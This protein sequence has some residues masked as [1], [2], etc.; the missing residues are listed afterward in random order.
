ML[1]TARQVV[2][3]GATADQASLTEADAPSPV[4]LLRTDGSLSRT[5]SFQPS[6][7]SRVSTMEESAFVDDAWS[8]RS[9]F[10]V[11]AGVRYDRFAAIHNNTVS[12]RARLDA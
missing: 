6:D 12:P 5:I 11:N 10:V 4:S 1:P 2:K 7:P 8:P 3:I 9:S